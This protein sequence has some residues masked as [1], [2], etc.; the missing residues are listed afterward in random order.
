M[1]TYYASRNNFGTHAPENHEL[2]HLIHDVFHVGY[3]RILLTIEY[4]YALTEDDGI[5]FIHGNFYQGMFIL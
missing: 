2:P 5:I 4:S 1:C 3:P